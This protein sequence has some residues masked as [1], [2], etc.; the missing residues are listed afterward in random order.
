MKMKKTVRA[1]TLLALVLTLLIPAFPAAAG[2]EAV[3]SGTCRLT[4]NLDLRNNL[5]MARYGVTVCL[6]G[7]ELGKLCQGG[8]M[9]R[10]LDVS[11]GIH[12]VRITADRSD[13]QDMSFD[14]PVDSE[15]MLNASLQTHRQ[16]VGIVS[17]KVIF[18]DQELVY[19]DSGSGSEAGAA[20]LE[21]F[22]EKLLLH[23]LTSGL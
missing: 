10:I 4:V 22:L 6:D 19:R 9:L 12:T 15:M 8:S 23:V 3:S 1:L 5:V 21:A 13:V 16:Y 20:A 18:P 7:T 14:L 11:P 2:A 17:M